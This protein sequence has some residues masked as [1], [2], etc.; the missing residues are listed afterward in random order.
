MLAFISLHNM[1]WRQ[2]LFS[3]LENRHTLFYVWTAFNSLS[4]A[5]SMLWNHLSEFFDC[6]VLLASFPLGHLHPFHHPFPFRPVSSP[7][8]SFSGLLSTVS[9][10]V[11][12][13]TFPWPAISSITPFILCSIWISFLPFSFHF[14]TARFSLL[15]NSL[16]WLSPFVYIIAWVYHWETRRQ[17]NC[18]LCCLW[19][20]WVTDAQWPITDRFWKKWWDWSPICVP[21][22]YAMIYGLKS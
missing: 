2:Y 1:I 8:F 14:F 4:F 11:A 21:V 6:D 13:K 22:I 20:T 19:V 18:T 7:S 5:L 3:A 9:P 16:S 12:V 10:A 15:P 17:Q